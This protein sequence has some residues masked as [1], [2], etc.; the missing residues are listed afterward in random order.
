MFHFLRGTVGKFQYII[1]NQIFI[2]QSYQYLE[3]KMPFEGGAFEIV[4][5]IFRKLLDIRGLVFL[6]DSISRMH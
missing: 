1:N 3:T 4:F 6:T 2:I 5:F